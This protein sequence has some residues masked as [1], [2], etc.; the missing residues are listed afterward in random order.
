MAAY[1]GIG[2]S[3]AFYA[4]LSPLIALGMLVI[5]ALMVYPL[6]LL[7]LVYKRLGVSY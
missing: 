5:F 4:W 1:I 7:G 6:T 3:L 2:F